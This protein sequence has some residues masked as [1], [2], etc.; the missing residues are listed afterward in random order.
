MLRDNHH[1]LEHVDDYL[2]DVLEPDDAAYVELHCAACSVCKAGLEAARKRLAALETVPACEA[3]EQ[4]IQ[5]TLEKIDRQEE[6]RHRL[7]RRITWGIAGATA[8]A[9]AIISAFHIYYLNLR[10]TPYDLRI[11][12]QAQLLPGASG[13]L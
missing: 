9:V 11:L 4:L 3:S 10:P 6:N 1:V 7:R 5:G 13:A 2:H 12:G 8:A